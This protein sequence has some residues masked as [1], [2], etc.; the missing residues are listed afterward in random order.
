MNS[1]GNWFFCVKSYMSVVSVCKV[2]VLIWFCFGFRVHFMDISENLYSI[3]RHTNSERKK[4]EKT[5][6]C[7]SLK[8]S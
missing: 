6:A 3:C 8:T 1:S 7:S 2:F 5:H 4:K